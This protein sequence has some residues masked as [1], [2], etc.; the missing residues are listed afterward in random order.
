MTAKVMV[1]LP[2]ELVAQVRAVADRTHRTFDEVL[3]DWIA[4]V[5]TEPAV[6]T[7]PDAE[8]LGLADLQLDESMQLALEDLLDRQRENELDAEGRRE[9]D[10]VMRVVRTAM[11]RKAHALSVA[12]K[13]G[14]RARLN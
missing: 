11:V 2:D 9:L 6:E 8:L 14:L 3:A 13:R 1:E 12:V 5:G 4:Q 10:A 7:L